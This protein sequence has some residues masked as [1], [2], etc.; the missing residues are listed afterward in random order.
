[1]ELISNKLLEQARKK[2]NNAKNGNLKINNIKYSFIFDSRE[3]SYIVL[4]EENNEI[5]K[6]NTKSLK[7][8]REW[9]R[10]YFSN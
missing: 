6:F 7:Q 2:A 1:M 8:A 9:L 10:E 5:V 4:D 3:W